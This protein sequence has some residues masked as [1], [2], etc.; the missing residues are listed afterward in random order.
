MKLKLLLATLLNVSISFAQVP[1]YVTT[2]G[3]VGWWPFNGNANDLSVNNIST[4]LVN[5]PTYSNDRFNNANSAVSLDGV[6]D[7]INFP[8]GNSTMVNI[9][10]DYT[11]SFWVSTIDNSGLLVSFGD[12][13]NSTG[14]FNSGI[15]AG[16]IGLGK[17]AI[18]NSGGGWVPSTSTI[19]NNIWHH[20]VYTFES[21]TITMYIDNSL[22]YTQ[23]SYSPPLTWNG[24]RVVGCR[25]DLF[26][27]SS[28]NFAGLFDDF[29]I[30]NRAL[31]ECEI[32]DLYHAQLNS[33]IVDAGIDQTIC[34]G[35]SVTLTASNSMNY[36][37]NNNVVDG[38]PFT[39][40]ATSSYVVTADT[41]GCT[42]TDSLTVTVNETTTS[43][44][45][46]TATDTY[47][48]PSGIVF[49][50]SGVY[51]DTI[52]NAN[53]CDSIITINLTVEY[54]GINELENTLLSV[55]PNPTSEVLSI[56]GLEKLN[57]IYGYKIASIS[58]TVISEIKGQSKHVN[59]TGLSKGI[60]FLNIMH[61]E[62]I[63]TVQ[64]IKQ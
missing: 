14:G 57:G 59:V 17:L 37:W 61:E 13:V 11:I 18:I 41:A 63:E 44:I 50:S 58:G 28:T 15:N 20:I 24:N 27:A 5:G 43:T 60:Y 52:L 64:F 62:G 55:Y 51:I 45:D 8:N 4:S 7:Y 19:D 39:P 6:N 32:Q 21:N 38:S 3:L 12:N 49:D 31:N 34:S 1:D 36:S 40:N 53:Q 16:N 54:T 48:S 47:T 2:N 29:G 46:V 25:D 22:E 56:S 23:S 26:M 33:S 9:V 42:S 30:W 10:D 35:E